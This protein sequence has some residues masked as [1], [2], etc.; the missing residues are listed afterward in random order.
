MT[1]G[2]FVSFDRVADRYDATRGYPPGV[3]ERVADAIAEVGGL[4]KSSRVLEVGVGTGRIALPLSRRV[5]SIH[6]IDVSRPMLRQ[7]L[8]RRADAPLH[9]ALADAARPPFRDHC[10]DAALAVHVFHLIR[11]WREALAQLTRVLRPGAPLLHAGDRGELRRLWNLVVLS[12]LGEAMQ[13]V[14]VSRE[15]IDTFLDEEGWRPM[16]EARC[17]AYVQVVS[18]PGALQQLEERAW[19]AT[20]RLDDAQLARLVARVRAAVRERFG[21]LDGSVELER[22]FRVRAYLPPCG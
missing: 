14:G 9:V 21:S 19:S 5:G 22:E 15:R 16:G 18:L 7:L 1:S 4:G 8:A 12:E 20:W 2:P 6:G 17:V 11:R 13:D 3:E 10:F